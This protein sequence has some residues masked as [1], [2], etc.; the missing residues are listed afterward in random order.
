MNNTYKVYWHRINNTIF[1]FTILEG[2]NNVFPLYLATI[3]G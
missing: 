1:S 2:R 3:V